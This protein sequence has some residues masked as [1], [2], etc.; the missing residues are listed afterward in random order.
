MNSKQIFEKWTL[1]KKFQTTMPSFHFF[2]YRH[3][4][5]QFDTKTNCRPCP[6]PPLSRGAGIS[7]FSIQF[8]EKLKK[9][10]QELC[11]KCHELHYNVIISLINIF[12]KGVSLDFTAG[13]A[14]GY[15]SI[16]IRV[17]FST[18]LNFP[19]WWSITR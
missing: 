1:L 5:K 10:E 19:M 17:T 4:S 6:P 12:I 2:H 7:Q 15:Y 8:F 13:M 18:R 3:F 11:W 9:T 14:S 16:L